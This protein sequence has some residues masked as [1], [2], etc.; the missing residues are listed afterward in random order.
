MPS[1]T[2]DENVVDT[3]KFALKN[4]KDPV[5][6]KDFTLNYSIDK[7]IN[8]LINIYNSFK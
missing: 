5:M 4:K 3:L 1:N 8:E 7:E 2:K 6:L